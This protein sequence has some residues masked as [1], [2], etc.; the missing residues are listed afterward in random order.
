MVARRGRGT[1]SPPQL[2]QTWS[3]CGRAAGAEGALEAADRG[4]RIVRQWGAAALA[5]WSHLQHGGHSIV[6]AV[7]P[8]DL[9]SD[10]VTRPTR[11]MRRAMAEA[12]VGDDVWGDDP[13]VI[14]LE[15]EVAELLGKEAAVYVPSGA[16]GNLVSVRS[17]TRPGDEILVHELAHIVVHEQGGAAV[18]AGVQTRTVAGERGRARHRGAA[19][20]PARSRRRPYRP[21]EPCLR[22]EHGRRAGRA[23]L[24]RR[25][26]GGPGR[27]RP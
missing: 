24:S 26:P 25:P 23:G 12:E 19:D 3:I 13:T 7:Q 22:R 9:R 16:M 11:E 21:A 6:S 2:G 15:R 27:L 8:V 14:E 4:R 1:S 10:T 17:Q 18:L 20:A 5:G